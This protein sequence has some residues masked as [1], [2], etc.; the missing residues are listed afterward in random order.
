M[1]LRRILC[2]FGW[3][4]YETMPGVAFRVCIV[5]HQGWFWNAGRWLR[6][7]RSKET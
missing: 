5:C 4:R 6:A 3:H 7:K 1:T 2:Y